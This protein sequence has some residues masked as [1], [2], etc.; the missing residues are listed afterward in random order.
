MKTI[1][2]D[3]DGD[4]Y[5]FVYRCGHIGNCSI[6]HPMS[7]RE[8]RDIKRESKSQLCPRCFAA[9]EEVPGIE[10]QRGEALVIR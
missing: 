1:K 2:P 8:Y 5:F 9:L 7:Q 3:M 6:G 4:V 10:V